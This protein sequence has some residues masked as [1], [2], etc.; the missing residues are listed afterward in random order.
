MSSDAEKL[1]QTVKHV[2]EL[3]VFSKFNELEK[4]SKGKHLKAGEIEETLKDYL[5]LAFP[6][7]SVFEELDIIKIDSTNP[8]EW[9]VRFDL[10]TEEGLSDLS[11]EVTLIKTN[12]GLFDVE[13]DNIHVL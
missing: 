5:T 11:L 7:D 4:F 6:P 9:S 3:L 2:V 10:W 12:A 13:V 8:D 1:K